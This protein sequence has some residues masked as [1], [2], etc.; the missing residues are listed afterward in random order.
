[1]PQHRLRLPELIYDRGVYPGFRDCRVRFHAG[2]G[3]FLRRISTKD[4]VIPIVKNTCRLI[5]PYNIVKG[6]CKQN[7]IPKGGRKIRKAS[8]STY[9]PVSN[10]CD[11]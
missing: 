7:Y 4:E 9:K 11:I 8:I 2:A 1:M 10:S 3:R 6:I 5:R